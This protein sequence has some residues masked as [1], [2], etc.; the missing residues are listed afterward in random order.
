MHHQHCLF[1]KSAHSG[2]LTSVAVAVVQDWEVAATEC[3]GQGGM[4]NQA[5]K[6]FVSTGIQLLLLLLL[7][8]TSSLLPHLGVGDGEGLGGGGEGDGGWGGLLLAGA[9]P[10]LTSAGCE[11]GS[12]VSLLTALCMPAGLLLSAWARAA[13]LLLSAP[14]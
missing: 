9:G 3:A 14:A 13:A 5:F 6:C 8:A 11:A 12:P 4:A 10:T 2:P 1:A 7:V